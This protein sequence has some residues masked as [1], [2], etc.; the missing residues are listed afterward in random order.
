MIYYQS[1][2]LADK[3]RI[4][5]E[6]WKRW[7]REFLPPDPLGGLQSGYARQFSLRDAFRVFI[8][9][10]LVSSLKF[11]VAEARTIL[12]DLQPWL[13]RHGFFELTVENGHRKKANAGLSHRVYIMHHGADAFAY[14]V[15]TYQPRQDAD[16]GGEVVE[17]Y[18]L[19]LINTAADDIAAGCTSS[20]RVV[21][22]TQ[23]YKEFLTSI[24]P[25]T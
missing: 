11:S 18:A 1:R 2:Y 20:A 4:K 19:T 25:K 7:V 13:K 15:R 3:T 14:A 6:R 5:P 16:D 9:G 24:A 12:A 21:D 23:L 22:M 10:Y 8:G 17:R